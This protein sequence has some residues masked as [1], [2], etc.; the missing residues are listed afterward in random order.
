MCALFAVL[1]LSGCGEDKY[2][3]SCSVGDVEKIEIL[4]ISPHGDRTVEELQII[5]PLVVIP[6][7]DHSS[8]LEGLLELPCI[9]QG[10]DPIQGISYDTVRITYTDSS[11]EWISY[12]C[13]QYYNVE[14]DQCQWKYYY[15]E[16]EIFE[17]FISQYL[18][19]NSEASKG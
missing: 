6:E 7:N 5:E 16:E 3:L 10:M 4:Y 13:S 18:P 8:F 11:V 17:D 15:F 14:A 12:M 19:E 2:E 1:L 9:R